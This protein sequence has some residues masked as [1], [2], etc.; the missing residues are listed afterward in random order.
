MPEVI[1][2]R[3]YAEELE[4]GDEIQL[5]G[6]SRWYKILD[7][8]SDW[9]RNGEDNV[10]LALEGYGRLCAYKKAEFEKR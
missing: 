5:S 1:G 7:V 8:G 3:V 2:M 6:Y 9:S 4:V 10:Y